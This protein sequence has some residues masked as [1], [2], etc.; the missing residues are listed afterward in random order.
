MLYRKKNK[1]KQLLALLGFITKPKELDEASE[2]EAEMCAD[3]P[4]FNNQ[5]S[6]STFYRVGTSARAQQTETLKAGLC[7]K[8]QSAASPRALTRPIILILSA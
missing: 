3:G 2:N 4:V 8:P 6:L 7:G 1:T 5:A